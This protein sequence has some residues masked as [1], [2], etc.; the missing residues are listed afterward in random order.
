MFL[1]TPE[2]FVTV[3]YSHPMFVGPHT[4]KLDI[5]SRAETQD[6]QWSPA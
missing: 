3:E 6:G 5:Y 4:V 2:R 1:L